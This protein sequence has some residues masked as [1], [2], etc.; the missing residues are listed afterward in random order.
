MKV[1]DLVIKKGQQIDSEIYEGGFIWL[2]VVNTAVV[3]DT[4]NFDYYKLKELELFTTK[5]ST[6]DRG[7]HL[8]VGKTLKELESESRT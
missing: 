5:Y 4:R 7:N 2:I 3:S 1:G 8:F 6:K